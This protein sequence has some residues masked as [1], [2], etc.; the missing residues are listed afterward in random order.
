MAIELNEISPGVELYWVGGLKNPRRELVKG[1]LTRALETWRHDWKIPEDP[2]MITV[3]KCNAFLE[4]EA[5]GIPFRTG[6]AAGW[7]IYLRYAGKL[8]TSPMAPIGPADES[9]FVAPGPA[10]VLQP[11]NVTL[12][13]NKA[14]DEL[15]GKTEPLMVLGIS[16]LAGE[17]VSKI[18]PSN[19]RGRGRPRLAVPRQLIMPIDKRGSLRFRAGLLGISAATLLRREREAKNEH[20]EM[21]TLS[22]PEESH[23]S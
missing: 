9:V 22:I 21:V 6:G 23:L 2:E 19:H 1:D 17:A 13:E 20:K 15:S 16:T 14:V 11:I 8:R 7:G 5:E 4:D 10:P 3:H 12:T 18:I